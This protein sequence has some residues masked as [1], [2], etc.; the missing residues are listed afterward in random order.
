MTGARVHVPGPA[1][2]PQVRLL[3]ARDVAVDE[4]G[5]RIWARALTESV[6]TSRVSRS[7]AFPY[8]LVAWH[9]QAVG[10]DIER[11]GPCSVEFAQL[12]CTPSER[13]HAVSDRALDEHLTSLWSS[14]EALA[15]ALG[16]ALRYEPSRLGSPMYWPDGR[17]G[18]WSAASLRA[19]TGHFA[20]LCWRG[21]TLVPG[22]GRSQHRG[23]ASSVRSSVLRAW[24]CATSLHRSP[25]R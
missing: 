7:Y 20:W 11:V 14:K 25:A 8:A 5:L 16:D 1:P 6:A 4:D 2:V 22:V 21:V 12:V 17:A 15:K 10:I 19:P 9:D 13:A 18:A 3:D 23:S 24:T